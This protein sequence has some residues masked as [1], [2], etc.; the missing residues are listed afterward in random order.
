MEQFLVNGQVINCA[1]QI[2]CAT[3]DTSGCGS[4]VDGYFLNEE[5]S[6]CYS[7][8]AAIPACS[9]CESN[10]VCTQCFD[11]M[12]LSEDGSFCLCDNSY[13]EETILVDENTGLCTCS[14]ADSY[15]IQGQ[16]CYS[17]DSLITDC[18]QCS[19]VS[20][21]TGYPLDNQR[22]QGTFAQ[23]AYITC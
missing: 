10:S 22:L 23:A 4:C 7:C 20:W 15:L 21:Y 19:E 2:G 18:L 8:N 9:S 5:E 1:E 17:C 3:C 12:L 6:L 16:G 13:D 11:G 14:E